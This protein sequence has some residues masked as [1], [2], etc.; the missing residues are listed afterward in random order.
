MRKTEIIFEQV[1]ACAAGID[2]GSEKIFVSPDGQEVK[3]FGTCSSDYRDCIDYLKQW[4]VERVA[5]EATGVYWISLYT[6]LEAEGIRVSLVN[7]KQTQQKRGDKTD[8]KDARRIQKL[9]AAGILKESF[10]PEGKMLEIRLLVRERLDIIDMGSTYIKKMQRSLELMNIK[11][12]SVISQIHGTSGIRM[13]EAIIAGQR[14]AQVLLLLCHERI[15]SK[16][17]AEVLKALE[18]N[19]NETYLFMLKQNLDMWKQHQQQVHIIDQR[20]ALLLTNLVQDKPA[21]KKDALGKAKSIRHHAPQIKNLHAMMVQL[22]GVNV[23]SIS[24]INDYT[25]LRLIGETG[26]DMSRF[27]SLKQFTSWCSLSPGHHQSGKK[28]KWIKRAPCN[29]AGQIFKEV[30]QSLQNSKYTA[31]GAFIRKLKVRRGA[32]IA[33]KAGARKIAEA[34]YN[35]LTKGVEYVEQGIKKYEQQLKAKEL[36]LLQRLAKKHEL[37]VI[38]I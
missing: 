15:K 18:G 11:L 31:I 35:T 36:S 19:Y 9:F 28:S 2:I 29:K 17:S 34:F 6:M 38:G 10:I 7:P 4:G 14:D 20:I 21:V 5:M 3:N 27:P 8:V 16:K 12:T 37:Q 13:I 33:Y 1:N 24:G 22:F 25:L 23:S 30:A 32:A 26:V